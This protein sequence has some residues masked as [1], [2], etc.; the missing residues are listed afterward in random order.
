M[1]QSEEM[2]PR[3]LQGTQTELHVFPDHY[4]IVFDQNPNL[5]LVRS[6]DQVSALL[7]DLEE[8]A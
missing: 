8:A 2:K 7:R 4:D 5:K 3:V 6:T 1:G